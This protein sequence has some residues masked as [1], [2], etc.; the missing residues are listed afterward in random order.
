MQEKINIVNKK[1]NFKYFLK[2]KYVAGLVLTGLQIKTIRAKKV[3]I[4]NSYCNFI[5]D[6]L[7]VFN[8]IFGNTPT[9][10]KS[11]S[12]IKL[13]LNK[14]EL[15]KIRSET[16]VLGSTLIPSKIFSND[17]G[18]AKIEVSIAKGK[19][20]YDKRNTIKDRESKINL[21]RRLKS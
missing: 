4:E 17:K 18:I 21:K 2:K 14:F 9:E 11:S 3:I 5:D 20:L 10:K 8:I 13:L 12:K 16:N 7:F 19:K 1:A 15:K 6:E